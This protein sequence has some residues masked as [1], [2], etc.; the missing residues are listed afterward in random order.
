AAIFILRSMPL[1]EDFNAF[2]ITILPLLNAIFNGFAFVF[3]LAALIAIMRGNVKVH[4]RFIYAAIVATALFLVNYVIF[5][6]IASATPFRGRGMI[7]YVYYTSLV[8]HI[9]LSLVII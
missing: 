3:L 5:H 6:F 1:V 7:D 4:Q 8:S 2:D 9:V